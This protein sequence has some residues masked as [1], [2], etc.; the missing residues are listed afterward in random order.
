MM[1]S[2]WNAPK[3]ER[4]DYGCLPRRM[5]E[6][7]AGGQIKKSLSF[8]ELGADKF[9]NFEDDQKRKAEMMRRLDDAFSKRANKE[10]QEWYKKSF[11]EMFDKRLEDPGLLDNFEYF[12]VPSSDFTIMFYLN[13]WT[14]R[15]AYAMMYL[16]NYGWDLEDKFRRVPKVDA[17][18]QMNSFEGVSVS[19]RKKIFTLLEKIDYLQMD[20]GLKLNVFSFGG[21]NEPL[22]L[23]QPHPFNWVM[24]DDIMVRDAEWMRS[25][26]IYDDPNW[27]KYRFD[28]YRENLFQAKNHPDLF[29]VNWADFGYVF[30]ASIYLGPDL[31]TQALKVA[32][33]L[34]ANGGEIMFDISLWTDSMRR[35]V[36]T[37]GWPKNEEE[38]WILDSVDE[39]I[40]AARAVIKEA[41]QGLSGSFY[42]EDIK[43]I[44][45]DP[46]GVTSVIFTLKKISSPRE[47]SS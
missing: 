40:G 8:K 14:G 29:G 28:Y 26:L 37:Q 17:W 10:N 31:L 3:D 21:G 39:A 7:W 23:Y 38:M 43:P 27:E 4:R 41:S 19:E 12:N 6:E 16:H 45:V 11:R 46:W 15:I 42:I 34:L 24:F 22:R 36:V 9:L 25:Q 1:S 44:L 13:V 5:M 18:Y 32:F 33:H 20:K 47:I 2:C 35:L 30:G